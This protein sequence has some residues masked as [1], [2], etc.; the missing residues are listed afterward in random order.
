MG[1]RAGS[2]LTRFALTLALVYGLL[3]AM[4]W[5]APGR[6]IDENLWGG[7]GAAA[8]SP[9]WTSYVGFSRWYAGELLTGRGGV[10]TQYGVP[11]EELIAERVG[12]SAGHLW[13]GFAAAWAG[14]LAAG[15]LSHFWP[16]C[17]RMALGA[18][19]VVLSLPA[20]F[21]V[22]TATLA[23]A[24]AWLGLAVCLWPKTYSYWEAILETARRRSH[25]LALMAQGAGPWTVQWQGVWRPSLR[26]LTGL[27]AVSVPLLFGTLIPV[28]VLCDEPG[29]G[30]LA[31]RAVAGRDL[32]LLTSLTLLFTA[33]TS[34]A[35]L[36]A[37]WDGLEAG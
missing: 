34:G 28:E 12:V 18:G 4:L 16:V 7:Y 36:F 26:Q 19:S 21:L 33:A 11:V 15:V 1:R 20:A 22:L 13:R 17:G 3:T 14:A 35:G 10:S 24:P 9:Q 30:Q 6:D 23:G 5:H 32:P 2:A 27:V 37:E 29:L 25:V 31:W 8:E